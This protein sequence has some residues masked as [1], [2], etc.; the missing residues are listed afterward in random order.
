MLLIKQRNLLN[1]FSSI[2]VRKEKNGTSKLKVEKSK[3]DVPIFIRLL[4][5]ND[6]EQILKIKRRKKV[7]MRVSN[8]ATEAVLHEKAEEKCTPIIVM[9]TIL[10]KITY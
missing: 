2:R 1:H 10:I 3:Q 4:E 6:K 7:G 8:A 9:C 5:W